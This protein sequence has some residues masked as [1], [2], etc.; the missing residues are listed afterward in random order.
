MAT[1][2]EFILYIPMNEVFESPFQGRFLDLSSHN[3]DNEQDNKIDELAK[4]IEHSGL[5]QPIVVR[6]VMNGYELIDGH[7]RFLACK[8]LGWKKIKA[9]VKDISDTEAQ[10]NSIVGNLQRENLSTIE[11]AIAYKKLLDTNIFKD[12]RELSSAFGKDETYV[13]DLLHTLEM[14]GRIIEYLSKSNIIKDLR[15]LRLIRNYQ[16]VD[17]NGF[18]DKQWGL[19]T[20]VIKEGLSRAEVADI[21]KSS[22]LPKKMTGFQVKKNKNNLSFSVDTREWSDEKKDNFIKWLDEVVGKM[23]Q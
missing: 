13:G 3:I 18:S 1:E 12:K 19:F 17:N 16:K 20:K 9:I 7:R 15:L 2:K 21:V 6:T 22:K 14:D 23:S 8:K 10:I 11:L 4:S 5:L